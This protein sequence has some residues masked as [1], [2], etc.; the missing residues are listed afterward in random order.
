MVSTIF[1][2]SSA[3]V[4]ALMD[5]TQMPKFLM[6]YKIQDD[7]NVP[8]DRNRFLKVYTVTCKI[9]FFFQLLNKN[10]L[11]LYHL[12]L[13]S[14]AW[15]MNRF[16]SQF[17]LLD[18]GNLLSTCKKTIANTFIS[19]MVIKNCFIKKDSGKNHE[20]ICNIIFIIFNFIN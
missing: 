12:R 6:K 20:S 19:H 4:Y 7:K 2:W 8:L 14:H 18:I 10:I 17:G 5:F 11:H 9:T 16:T 3:G 1:Y 13:F 15:L